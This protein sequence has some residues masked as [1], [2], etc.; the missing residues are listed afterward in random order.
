M[1]GRRLGRQARGHDARIPQMSA[2]TAGLALPPPPK[3]IDWSAKLPGNLGMMGNAQ[4]GDCIDAGVYHGRQVWTANAA[5]LSTAPDADVLKL[6]EEASG[7]VPG[8]PSTDQGGLIQN[9]LAYWAKTGAPIPGG[10]DILDAYV[11]IDELS[12]QNIQRAIADCG[13]AMVGFNVPQWFV[14]QLNAGTLPQTWDVQPDLDNTIVDGHCVI[15]PGYGARGR[16]RVI[17][18]GSKGYWMTPAFEKQFVDEAYALI[19]KDWLEATGQ[20]PSWFTLPALE[21]AM[22]QIKGAPPAAASPAPAA[23][24]ER[25]YRWFDPRGRLGP[26]LGSLFRR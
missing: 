24:P 11:E 2:L 20:T 13:F 26:R 25:P 17:S 12:Q 5:T 22:A 9:V 1:A 10:V 4:Y 6:Y 7:Y 14:D 3:A 23:P 21:A 19:D 15:L 8:D 16:Y 18:W